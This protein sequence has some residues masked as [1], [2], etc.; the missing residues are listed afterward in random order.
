MT[1]PS[2]CR[3]ILTGFILAA[4]S[5][6]SRKRPADTFLNFLTNTTSIFIV[7]L[8]ELSQ[9]LMAPNLDELDASDAVYLYLGEKPESS[10]AIV[11]DQKLQEKRFKGAA[12]DMLQ[13]FLDANAYR[14]EPVKAFLRE[15]LASLILEMVLQ[16]CSKPEW[17]NGWIVYLLEQGEP[18]ILNAIDAGVGGA[19]ARGATGLVVNG[20]SPKDHPSDTSS[21]QLTSGRAAT[22]SYERQISR[23]QGEM[24]EAML[25]AKRLTALMLEEEVKEKARK[26]HLPEDTTSSGYGT[27]ANATPTSSQS[28]L[29]AGQHG[30][31][32]LIEEENEIMPPAL[33]QAQPPKNFTDFDQIL[34]SHHSAA[35]QSS[36][37][38][39]QQITPPPLTLHNAK[40]SIF[41]DSQTGERASIRSK[42]TIDY[43]LQIEPVSSQYP[44]WMISRKYA[45]FETLHEV[46][47]RISVVSGVSAFTLKYSTVPNWK[48]QTNASFRNNLEDYLKVALSHDRL[49]E[50]EGMKRFLEKDRGLNRSP[51]GKG[52]LGFP[53]PEA[54][55]NMGKGMLDVLAGA[56]KGAAGGGKALFEGVTGVFSGPK[57][58]SHQA[59]SSRSVS[60]SS[61][62][63]ISHDR[64]SA[65]PMDE[66][67]SQDLSR[68]PSLIENAALTFPPRPVRPTGLDEQ[69][70]RKV[71]AV[72]WDSDIP[73]VSEHIPIEEKHA[74]DGQQPKPAAKIEPF[75]NLTLPPIEIPDKY[76][77]L[78]ASA[79]PVTCL[80]DTVIIR[81]PTG[82]QASSLKSPSRTENSQPND[83]AIT[84]TPTHAPPTQPNPRCDP[85][86]LSE[87]ETQVAVELFFA[88]INELYTLSS[89][90]NIRRTLLNAAK[91]F[92]LRP[93]NPSLEAIR[94]LLQITVIEAN[95]SDAGLARHLLVLRQNTLPTEE[96][97][98]A[99]PAPPGEEAKEALRV[100]ARRL[101]VQRGM[102]RALTS[103]M[104]AAATGEALGRVFDCLQVECVSRGLVFAVLLQGLR[105]ITH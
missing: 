102:P 45:D 57:K 26:L 25:E 88:V 11:L 41:D 37:D 98:A 51:S 6:L 8:S 70:Q 76:T 84:G 60:V 24:D 104:G 38:L 85:A 48:N 21:E 79:T 77:S 5:H 18:E 16:N 23:A 67:V 29:V 2:A 33:E 75:L 90:W 35:T 97:L 56:P 80:D 87:P 64:A 20:R 96:E 7:F 31:N 66:R 94:S 99:W 10:L 12:E 95:T 81:S 46:L 55:Q 89:A 15:I 52:L 9:A 49:A 103:V 50:S 83:E 27:A 61:N 32:S 100:K 105:A 43:L 34:S 14:C 86:P 4:S 40:V 42:P 30:L 65:K 1:F 62:T 13:K 73:W 54:F 39:L 17:I 69:E 58:S 47:R 101:L 91:S 19:T 36:I 53:S 71:T 68:D 63:R 3:K 93:R 74:I 78:A 44:G 28:D 72:S 59:K 22:P 92:L 82:S